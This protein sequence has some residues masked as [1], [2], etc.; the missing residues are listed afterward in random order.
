M[1]LNAPKVDASAETWTIPNF[2]IGRA[3][4]IDR[5]VELERRVE[6]LERKLRDLSR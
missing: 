2:E 3:E 4:P 1:D 6:D 5:T